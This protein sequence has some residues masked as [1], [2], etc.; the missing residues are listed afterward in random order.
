MSIYFLYLQAKN[1]QWQQAS[2]EAEAPLYKSYI[3]TTH[4]IK[5]VLL[6]TLSLLSLLIYRGYIYS[7]YSTSIKLRRCRAIGAPKSSLSRVF[8]SVDRVT[9]QH[10]SRVKQTPG[11][12]VKYH[13][14]VL[15]TIGVSLSR[16]IL[17]VWAELPVHLYIGAQQHNPEQHKTNYTLT[18]I[19]REYP[20]TL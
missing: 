18:A 4:I 1:K 20:Q 19:Y 15:H 6:L 13:S 7:T 2:H 14:T 3:W 10:C 17:P 11:Y 16:H 12:Q 5:Q 9:Y 8:V